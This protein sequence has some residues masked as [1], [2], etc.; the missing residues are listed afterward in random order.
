M[1]NSE[2]NLIPEP[3]NP[4]SEMLALSSFGNT[5]NVLVTVIE[6]LGNLDMEAAKLAVRRTSDKFPRF[7]SCIREVRQRG[8]HRIVWEHRPDLP[9]RIITADLEKTASSSSHL[10][11][12]L[13][14]M[15]PHLDRNWDLFQEPSIEFHLVRVAPDR[16]II[17]PVLHHVAADAGT[18]SEV[19]RDFL[20]NYH[21]ILT[22]EKPHWAFQPEAISTSRKRQVKIKEPRWWNFLAEAREAVSNMFDKPTLPVG[23]GSPGDL[24]QYQIKRALSVE[25]TERIGKI[26]A[27]RGVSFV[28]LLTACSNTTID[29]WNAARNVSPGELTTSMSVNMK[30]RFRGFN[31]DNN[32][33]LLFFRSL[34][35]ERENPDAFMRSLSLAR[36]K[37]FRNNKDFKFYQDVSRMT[38]AFRLLPFGL[39]SRIVHSLMQKHQF[40]VAITMLGVIWPAFKNGKPTVDT[41]LTQAGNLSVSTVHGIGYKLL[42]NTHLLFIVYFFRNRLNI[43]LAAS[44]GLFTRE[45]SEAF[46]DL[47]LTNLLDYSKT[48]TA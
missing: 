25:D 16:H 14:H 28:D 23:S 4:L 32:S 36:I 27:G 26:S 37:Q 29:Q 47:M 12:Y 1:N 21:E 43:V 38:A 2:I 41:C 39:R 40:S 18:A 7:R 3:L 17:G 31:T 42:S 11:S 6:G 22:G 19:G 34:P 5:K 13:G 33:A 44:A 8:R 45:E 30:G 10:D 20:A 35:H 46:M 15:V 48:A 24:R 9:L